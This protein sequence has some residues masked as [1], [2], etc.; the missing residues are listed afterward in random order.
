MR[1]ENLLYQIDDFIRNVGDCMVYKLGDTVF[2]IESNRFIREAMVMKKS[3]DF[4]TLR[5]ADGG[6]IRLR[7]NR[8]FATKPEA[9]EKILLRSSEQAERAPRSPHSWNY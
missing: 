3:G 8:L 2:F 5:F 1:K 6:G 4:Y 7:E 9:E